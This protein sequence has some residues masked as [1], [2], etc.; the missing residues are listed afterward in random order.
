MEKKTLERI[1]GFV[2]LLVVLLSGKFFAS[3]TLFIR[4]LIGIGFGYTLRRASL[5]FAGSVYRA[6]NTGS[7]ALMRVLM[8]MFVISS[9][10]TGLII[11]GMGPENLDLNIYPI[12]FGLVIGALIFGIG[13]TLTS[14]CASGSLTS[15]V[16]NTPKGIIAVFTFGMGVFLGYPTR[17]W[18]WVNR[19]WFTS[20]ENVNG[21]FFPDWFSSGPAAGYFGA[22]IMTLLLA[23]IVYLISLRYEKKRAREGTLD[24]PA[25][26]KKQ[27]AVKHLDPETYEPFNR[28]TYYYLFERPWQMPT[29]AAIMALLFAALLVIS[30]KGW[31]V[32]SS[33]GHWFGRLF[34]VFGATPEGLANFTGASVSNYE[35]SMF[36]HAGIMQNIGIVLGAL[37]YVLMIGGFMDGQKGKWK[38]PLWQGGMYAVGGFLMGIGTRL[39]YGCNVGA[40]FTAIS[41]FSLSGWLWLVFMV[42]GGIVGVNLNRL[43]TEY[44][45]R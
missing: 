7:T 23:G 4:F 43:W 5:G 29:G 28:D 45:T 6:T 38:L 35:G 14:C 19:S 1:L 11:Y 41:Q 22:F 12:N 32:S 42:L 31:G 39:S 10:L 40:F 33:L 2:L 20:S 25:S 27:A 37:I 3:T 9:L 26:E 8:Y 30:E 15:L 34:K 24:A 21:V 17:K 13:M 18:A 36:Q 44:N 16:G